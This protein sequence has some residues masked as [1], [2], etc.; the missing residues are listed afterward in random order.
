MHRHGT[1]CGPRQLMQGLSLLK[2]HGHPRS[3]VIELGELA[4]CE[5]PLPMMT[6][7]DGLLGPEA[8]P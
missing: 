3:A 7:Y 1:P 2:R 4:R 8:T 6:A 5:R